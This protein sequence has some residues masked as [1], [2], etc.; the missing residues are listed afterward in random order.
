MAGENKGN[1]VD[2]LSRFLSRPASSIPKG[3]QW[4]VVFDNL[5]DILPSISKAYGREPNTIGAWRTE[6]AAAIILGPDYQTDKGCLFCQAI[7]LPGE[8]TNTNVAGDLG[9]QGAQ[10]AFIRSY[11]GGGRTNFP[12]M[13]MTFLD[14]HVS[15]CE[16]FLRGWALA[17]ANFGMVARSDII[18]RTNLTCH[19]FGIT[20]SGPIIRQTISFNGVC[21]ISVSEEEYNYQTATAPL[22]REARFVY[23]SYTVNS[24]PIDNTAPSLK[25]TMA[26]SNPFSRQQI[27]TTSRIA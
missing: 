2:F 27:E 3:A 14:T 21:C 13:R 15:F 20:P 4:A 18:Y 22:E 16:S 9:G 25:P 23:H 5:Q 11:V 10:S 1:P 19:K 17:T 26:V 8:A 6:E 12:E 24:Y 7:G